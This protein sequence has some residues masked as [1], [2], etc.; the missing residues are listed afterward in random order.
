MSE[1]IR[2]AAVLFDLDGTLI[3][4]IE[5]ILRCYRHTMRTHLGAERDDGEWIRNMGRPLREQ[6]ALFARSV[7]EVEA[8]VETYVGLQ[9]QIHDDLVRPY[10]GA[11]ETL[12]ALEL[13]GVPVAIVTS[14]RERMT[15]RGLEHC[16]IARHFAVVVTPDD[17]RRAKPDPEPVLLALRRLG[18]P[19]PSRVLFV[20]DS[21]HDVAAGR[22]A[23]V[24]TAGALWGPFSREALVASGPDFLLERMPDLLE[25]DVA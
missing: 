13:L 6:L 4:S 23:G 11:A 3:D 17:V 25:L 14:K 5:L 8:M 21:P 18:D 15:R 19:P 24:R 10:P 16:G 9:A 7:D 20:G 2:W 1:P 12:A 22:A